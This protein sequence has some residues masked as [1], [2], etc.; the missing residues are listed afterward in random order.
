MS[1]DKRTR[2]AL[3][4]AVRDHMAGELD[5][6]GEVIVAWMTIAATRS[7]DGGGVIIYAGS[8][9]AMPRWQVRGLVEE[10]RALLN[11]TDDQL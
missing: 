5:A 8:D 11:Q 4:Q 9:E 7:H 6:D 2:D 3:D 1:D 10:M